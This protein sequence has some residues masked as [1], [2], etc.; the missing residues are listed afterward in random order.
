MRSRTSVAGSFS[1]QFVSSL[2]LVCKA[3]HKQVCVQGSREPATQRSVPLSEPSV[4]NHS[5]L[6]L[7]FEVFSLLFYPLFN[8]DMP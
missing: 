6:S 2:F 1:G 8:S 5:S 3:H 4:N 7:K